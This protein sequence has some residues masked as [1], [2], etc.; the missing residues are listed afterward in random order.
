MF[1]DIA[2]R[3]DVA[4]DA[5]S[6]GTHRLWRALAVEKSKA[7]A[8]QSVL[9]CASGT[10]DLAFAFK[11]AVGPSGS[12]VGTDFNADMLSVA[13][14]KASSEKVDV[15][16]EV[17]DVLALPYP[18][19]SFDIASIAFGIRNVDDPLR[20]LSELAR[21]TKPGGRVVV[22]EF[23]QPKGL[24]GAFFRLYSRFVMPALGQLLTGHRAAYEYLPRTSAVFPAGERFLA[25]MKATGRLAFSEAQPLLFGLAYIYVGTVR[26][27]V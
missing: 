15:R 26:S 1:S 10:G 8:G 24:F 16:F 19:A 11:R 17:A 12:V 4:N 14:E 3:Y 20:C 5:L 25:L 7:C 21:V 6:L 2:P 13:A 23:G 9:D 27:D 18:E 22:L